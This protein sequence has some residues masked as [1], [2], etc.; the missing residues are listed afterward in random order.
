M[1]LLDNITEAHLSLECPCGHAPLVP[2]VDFLNLMGRTATFD[3]V[4]GRARCSKCDG[5]ETRLFRIVSKVA[6]SRDCQ[7]NDI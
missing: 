2:V 7:F 1:T 5:R 3:D 4:K 6:K